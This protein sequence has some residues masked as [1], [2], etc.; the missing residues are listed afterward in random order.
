MSFQGEPV[1]ET[2]DFLR[3]IAVLPKGRRVS[4]RVSQYSDGKWI[5]KD[6]RITLDGVEIV[7]KSA[8]AGRKVPEIYL[9]H[10]VDRTLSAARRTLQ[11]IED[12]TA[13]GTLT[14]RGRDPKPLRISHTA[15]SISRK[16]GDS[17]RTATA[18]GG[19]DGEK[20]LDADKRKD[21]FERRNYWNDLLSPDGSKHFKS[22]KL[23]G[24]ALV[25]GKT[26]DRLE[27]VAKD[28]SERAYFV[29]LDSGRLVRADIKSRQWVR[30]IS[31]FMSDWRDAG[32]RMR[33]YRVEIWDR[34]K[35]KL[36]QT[37][38]YESITG[39]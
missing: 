3:R 2:N 5:E 24:G 10:E 35:E 38:Q 17:L 31:L 8:V 22:I 9:R 30:W 21:M 19:T 34:D 1:T 20:A 15:G 4:L 28:G 27:A 18:D 11:P 29:D 14:V 37:I 33:P 39:S 6:L 7:K 25:N 12:E 13:S 26:V 23:T 32:G 16:Y 36:L